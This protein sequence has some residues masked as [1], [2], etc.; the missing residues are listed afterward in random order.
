MWLYVVKIQAAVY[1]HSMKRIQAY[2][3]ELMPNGRQQRNMR[4][5]AG[6]C[7]FVFNKSL[8]WQKEQYASDQTIRFSYTVLA[9][10]LPLWK[11]DPNLAWLKNSPSQALQQTLKDLER[12]YK[13]FFS[14][15]ADF[16]RF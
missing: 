13:N 1:N 2:K 8:A 4:R 7:R 12:A 16:P 15:R 11:Q 5:F 6:A 14:K 3:F 9:N 10:L